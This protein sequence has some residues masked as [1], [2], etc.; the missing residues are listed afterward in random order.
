MISAISFEAPY[1]DKGRVGAVSCTGTG[2]CFIRAV[3]G[4]QLHA[5]L[6]Y[7][8][9]PLAAACEAALADV[10]EQNGR[11]GIIA[12][13]REGNLALPFN[14]HLMYRAWAGADAVLR[15]AVAGDDA[16]IVSL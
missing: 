8:G 14:S 2:E 9:Q 5:R 11:G 1:G 7:A 6:L 13:D 10:F 16:A 15:V 3:A 4:H 12:I